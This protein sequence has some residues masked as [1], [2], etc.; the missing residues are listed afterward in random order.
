M[1]YQSA[2]SL[3]INNSWVQT[4]SVVVICRRRCYWHTSVLLYWILSIQILKCLNLMYIVSFIFKYFIVYQFVMCI[5]KFRDFPLMVI[6][7]WKLFNFTSILQT[8]YCELWF[9]LMSYDRWLFCLLLRQLQTVEVAT[10]LLSSTLKQ[11]SSTIT[12]QP[13]SYIVAVNHIL[14]DHMLL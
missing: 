7:F 4:P 13:G 2:Q 3:W 11:R 5:A 14:K 1:P 9:C 10:Q 12:T 8:L 6:S